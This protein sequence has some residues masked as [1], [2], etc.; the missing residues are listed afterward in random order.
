M[1]FY[2]LDI[3]SLGSL[4]EL[5]IVAPACRS[6]ASWA[7]LRGTLERMHP[8]RRL[9]LYIYGGKP[10]E[11]ALHQLD[12]Y[13]ANSSAKFECVDIHLDPHRDRSVV[14]NLLPLSVERYGADFCLPDCL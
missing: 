10:D 8:L 14:R 11:W 2:R 6:P 9:S 4:R 12:K 3:S 5:R 13:L 1:L 7:W